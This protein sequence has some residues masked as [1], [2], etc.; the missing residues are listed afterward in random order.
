[1]K[2]L[3]ALLLCISLCLS[4]CDSID[5]PSSASQSGNSQSLQVSEPETHKG[6][7]YEIQT[8]PKE[9]WQALTQ[10]GFV[11]DESGAA[12]LKVEWIDKDNLLFY[13]YRMEPDLTGGGECRI[14][15]YNISSGKTEMTAE[16]STS[17]HNISMKSF[18]RNSTPYVLFTAFHAKLYELNLSN[19][20]ASISDADAISELSSD[21]MVLYEEWGEPDTYIY[22]FLKRAEFWENRNCVRK[23]Q[24]D[25]LERFVS[26]SPDGQYILFLRYNN[27]DEVYT[28]SK[29]YA[30]Y[31][32]LGEKVTDITAEPSIQWCQEPG[33]LTYT[34]AQDGTELRVLLDLTTGDESVLPL[35]M[36]SMVDL[37]IQEPRFSILRFWQESPPAGIYFLDHQTGDISPIEIE[38]FESLSGVSAVY[39][40]N[41]STVMLECWMSND[42]DLSSWI[43]C[44]LI[45]LK[46]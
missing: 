21:G 15:S 27:L 5:V 38:N 43:D 41:A 22:D 36:E 17:E 42:D 16:Y 39:N 28:D 37:L 25:P 7:E 30:I 10:D 6:V 40:S 9:H 46:Q 19:H 3:V 29:S 4:G 20:S 11:W 14:F 34:K 32:C 44:I 2:L 1:M 26:W 12:S 31:N 23:F 35:D 33:F 45:K 24:R 8:L 18:Q 13:M